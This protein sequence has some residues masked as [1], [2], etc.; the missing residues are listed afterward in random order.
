MGRKS[1][2]ENKTIF[3]QYREKAGLTVD[4]ATELM[5]LGKGRLTKIENESTFAHPDE[6][7]AMSKCYNAPELCN[8][9]CTNECPLGKENVPKADTSKS[10]EKLTLE[11]LVSLN[12]LDKYKDRLMEITVDG[13][14][15]EDEM[16][17][18]ELIRSK[19]NEIS[20][21]ISSLDLW[22]KKQN[23]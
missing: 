21:A 10:I 20:E 17:D 15:S 16:P 11:M 23:I 5:N 7:L 2:R 19:L 1:T 14:V 12:S 13:E 18:F 6:V 22:I 9:F 3:Q 4:K 8:L